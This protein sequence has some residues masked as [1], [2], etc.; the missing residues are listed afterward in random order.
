MRSESRDLFDLWCLIQ[1]G[2]GIKRK[3]IER[4]NVEFNL[5]KLRL[6]SKNDYER[7]LKN[8]LPATIPDYEQVVDDV[9]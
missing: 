4:K 5:S 1:D 8:L 3:I 7:G 6:P 9:T 2:V